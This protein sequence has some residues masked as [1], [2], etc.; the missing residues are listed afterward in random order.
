MYLHSWQIP[1]QNKTPWK[2]LCRTVNQRRQD[3][4]FEV[5]YQIRVYQSRSNRTW[6][7]DQF[8]PC[9]Y[10]SYLCG[11][12]D[13]SLD[14]DVAGERWTSTPATVTSFHDRLDRWKTKAAEYVL[15]EYQASWQ[16]GKK[17]TWRIRNLLIKIHTLEC[18]WVIEFQAEKAYTDEGLRPWL[19]ATGY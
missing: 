7:R 13:H 12:C 16:D 9:V 6:N 4:L 11:I 19:T 14:C 18:V 5:V 10:F 15:S 8:T 1:A 3:I 2:T 17:I